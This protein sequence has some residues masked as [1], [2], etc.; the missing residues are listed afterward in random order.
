MLKCRNVAALGLHSCVVAS[1]FI[2]LIVS[3]DDLDDFNTTK[4]ENQFILQ[5]LR[6]EHESSLDDCK[7]LLSAVNT[8]VVVLCENTLKK[9]GATPNAG[10]LFTASTALLSEGELFTPLKSFTSSVVSF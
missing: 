6:K 5:Q 4:E 8:R 1:V 3:K 7:R 2:A 9:F 10:V